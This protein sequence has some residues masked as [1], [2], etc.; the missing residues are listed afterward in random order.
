MGVA[1]EGVYRCRGC[2]GRG[3][4]KRGGLCRGC[5]GQGYLVGPEYQC[6]C[7]CG[8]TRYT[9]VLVC[10]V[11]YVSTANDVI[12]PLHRDI[13]ELQKQI[14]FETQMMNGFVN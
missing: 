1:F 12:H 6:A 7:I 3:V 4:S 10:R 11:C 13:S 5:A 14:E 9:N 8:C 2:K